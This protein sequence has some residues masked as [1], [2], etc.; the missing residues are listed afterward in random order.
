MTA[1]SNGFGVT[2]VDH[3]K[4]I[5]LKN[6]LISGNL[7]S[8]IMLV[9]CENIQI[10]GNIIGPDINGGLTLMNG[11]F[12]ISFN[13]N[14]SEN[15]VCS[16]IKIG[17][18]EPGEGNNISGN[19]WDGIFTGISSI[20][21]NNCSVENNTIS[22][23]SNSGINI[24]NGNNLLIKRNAIFANGGGIFVCGQG[25]GNWISENSIY[26]NNQIG[27]DLLSDGVTQNDP[28]DA[29]T[30]PNNFMNFPVLSSA[31][32]TPGKLHV[33]GTIDTPVP[34]NVIIEFFTN[35]VPTP[36]GD[37]S[38]YGEGAIFLGTVCPNPQGKFT[39]NLPTVKPGTLISATAT[40]SDGNT[41]EFSLNIEAK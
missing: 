31:K 10:E 32:I 15:N 8:G 30:G 24:A 35:P 19:G 12:G 41:S 2:I 17:G 37:P 20:V 1:L 28:G 3:S 4:N 18:K 29:D 6:N 14:E 16:L 11:E 7:Y 22:H 34:K 40:D 26:E 36:G 5:R 21:L 13:V 9:A 38:G 27:I 23:N 39:A 33:K 25:H